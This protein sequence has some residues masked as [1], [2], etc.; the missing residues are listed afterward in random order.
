MNAAL[1]PSPVP[2]A[3]AWRAM[4]LEDEELPWVNVT[5]EIVMA[6]DSVVVATSA[7]MWERDS[8][9]ALTVFPVWWLTSKSRG[10]VA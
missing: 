1:V 6:M 7:V 2:S 9:F 5:M 10:S 4:V 3:M 8:G